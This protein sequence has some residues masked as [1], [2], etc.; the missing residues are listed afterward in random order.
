M[1]EAYAN[2]WWLVL[3]GMVSG[4]AGLVVW[5]WRS[6]CGLCKWAGLARMG[7]TWPRGGSDD[8][9]DYGVGKG[10]CGM[11]R[12]QLL[13]VYSMTAYSWPSSSISFCK[14]SRREMQPGKGLLK[15]CDSTHPKQSP[16]GQTIRKIRNWPTRE[17]EL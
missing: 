2:E 9:W 12:E 13:Q 14:G 1:G 10:T 6:G 15:G 7:V 16:L 8:G 5:A 17:P 4:R 11:A 3:E